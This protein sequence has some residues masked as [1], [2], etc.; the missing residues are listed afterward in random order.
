L[1]PSRVSTLP[2]VPAS[3]ASSSKP[4]VQAFDYPGVGEREGGGRGNVGVGRR[5]LCLI[6]PNHH[7]STADKKCEVFPEESW[8]RRVQGSQKRPPAPPAPMRPGVALLRALYANASRTCATCANAPT[9]ANI[10]PLLDAFR[11]KKKSSLDLS[12]ISARYSTQGSRTT[13][14]GQPASTFRMHRYA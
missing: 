10:P 6:G 14:C 2:R 3:Q 4:W 11:A 13:T 12:Y 9:C 7:C 5:R 1:L 8:A